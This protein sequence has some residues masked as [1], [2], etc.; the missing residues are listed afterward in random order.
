[1]AIG[2]TYP[3]RTNRTRRCA[4]RAGQQAEDRGDCGGEI[5]HAI[6]AVRAILGIVKTTLDPRP[7]DLV[8]T[9]PLAR[10]SPPAVSPC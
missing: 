3:N 7:F 1:M 10:A 4:P 6:A 9:C 8:P 2:S 5:R